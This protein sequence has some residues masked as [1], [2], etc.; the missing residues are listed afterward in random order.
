MVPPAVAEPKQSRTILIV[1]DA[2]RLWQ[3][4]LK[5]RLASAGYI[6]GGQHHGDMGADALDR[7]LVLEGWHEDFPL[8]ARG[9]EAIAPLDG[10]PDIVIDLTTNAESWD[11]PVLT[12]E[13]GGRR[14]LGP[15]VA[16]VFAGATHVELTALLD[17][18]PVARASPMLGDRV[19]LSRLTDG[20]LAGAI[21]LLVQSVD[22]F[23]A[24]RLTP[25]VGEGP[26]RVEQRGIAMSYFISLAGGVATR[27][28]PKLTRQ[29][30]FYWQVAYRTIDGPGIPETGRLNGPSFTV[31]PDDGQRFYADPFVIERGGTSYLFVEEYPYATRRGV[32]SVAEMDDHGVFGTPRVVLQQP[33]HLSYPQIFV[34]A[35]E[36][37]MLPESGGAKELVLYRAAKFPDRWVRDT[38]LLEGQDVNDATLLVRDGRYWLFASQRFERGSASDT[39]CVFSAPSLR[40]PWQAHRDNPVII[41]LTAARPGGGFLSGNAGQPI[42]PVQDGRGGYGHGLGLMQLTRLDDDRVQFERPRPVQMGPAWRGRG[43]HTLN[44]AGNIE[45]VDSLRE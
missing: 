13:F 10:L 15:A 39:L 33:H 14:A 34:D 11:V 20:V 27:L 7:L 16:A 38:V 12:L 19:W 35:R 43:I 36:V 42:L 2:P 6:V 4:L 45:V 30:P 40:G 44:R 26:V 3:G 21:A 5:A 23:F 29:R 18:V 25:L 8:A 31:L 17:G 32:I 37:F 41:D 28:W 22:R 1:G 24:R 9:G